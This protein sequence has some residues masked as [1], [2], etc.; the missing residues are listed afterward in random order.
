MLDQTGPYASNTVTEWTN[1]I[2]VRGIVLISGTDAVSS[3]VGKTFPMQLLLRRIFS[4]INWKRA[5]YRVKRAVKPNCYL[6]GLSSSANIRKGVM[7]CHQANVRAKSALPS[8][9]DM[10]RVIRPPRRRGRDIRK[11]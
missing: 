9:A 8:T 2:V 6:A 3:R 1:L 10:A 11:L 7:N 5:Q 4:S